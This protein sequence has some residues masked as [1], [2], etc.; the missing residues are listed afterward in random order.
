MAGQDRGLHRR[1]MLRVPEH[2]SVAVFF[3]RRCG[4][5]LIS[6]SFSSAQFSRSEWYREPRRTQGAIWL[7]ASFVEPA[8]ACQFAA[9]RHGAPGQ[10]TLPRTMRAVPTL[11]GQCH[12]HTGSPAYVLCMFCGNFGASMCRQWRDEVAPAR[13]AGWPCSCPWCRCRAQR[14]RRPRSP[15]ANSSSS[16]RAPRRGRRNW[17]RAARSPT[18]TQSCTTC[19]VQESHPRCTSLA[20]RGGLAR[21]PR[22]SSSCG[23]RDTGC[24]KRS[25]NV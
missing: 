11:T 25:S 10:V 3:V 1:L 19:C 22:C 4:A 23:A 15:W 18:R 12:A 20:R 5:A 8:V 13:G 16:R 17:L 21:M 6:H 7:C 14:S 2:S 24:A 9:L